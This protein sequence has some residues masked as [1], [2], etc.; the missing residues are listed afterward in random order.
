MPT[1][2]A[3]MYTATDLCPTSSSRLQRRQYKF[4]KSHFLTAELKPELTLNR[5]TLS[6]TRK[7]QVRR[8]IPASQVNRFRIWK[9]RTAE[10][11]WS[12]SLPNSLQQ[13]DN[14]PMPKLFDISERV[15]PSLLVVGTMLLGSYSTASKLRRLKLQQLRLQQLP[16]RTKRRQA[17]ARPPWRWLLRKTSSA[18][19]WG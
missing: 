10:Q 19:P 14:E 2:C 13:W 6:I 7:P 15:A 4:S 11:H 1:V 12:T 16:P 9:V 8:K 17:G 3:N 5:N 18:M